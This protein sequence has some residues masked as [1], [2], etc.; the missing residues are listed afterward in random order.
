MPH[1]IKESSNEN[2]SQADRDKYT[3]GLAASSPLRGRESSRKTNRTQVD[4]YYE[5]P[6]LSNRLKSPPYS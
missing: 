6:E 1:S 3:F 5:S 2:K 4:V